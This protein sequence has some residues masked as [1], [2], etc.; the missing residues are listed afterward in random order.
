MYLPI[1][2]MYVTLL[3]EYTNTTLILDRNIMI[4][5]GRRENTQILHSD[6]LQKAREGHKRSRSANSY[7]LSFLTGSMLV[8]TIKNVSE[9]TLFG[10]NDP[11]VGT[12]GFRSST[13]PFLR[14]RVTTGAF[15]SLL[16]SL[17]S[18]ALETNS[19][20]GNRGSFM[21]RSFGIILE[22]SF[23]EKIKEVD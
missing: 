13:C 3:K 10:G 12:M 2:C 8:M 4:D 23:C 21:A 7:I 16:S 20:T 14:Q 15:S 9:L 6:P 17:L 5:T 18:A 1:F 19:A 11:G 22:C